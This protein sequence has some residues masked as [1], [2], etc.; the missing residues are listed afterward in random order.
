MVPWWGSD[1]LVGS[2]A[3]QLPSGAVVTK[4]GGD[5]LVGQ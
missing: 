4:Q 1:A 2:P 5:S 3:G